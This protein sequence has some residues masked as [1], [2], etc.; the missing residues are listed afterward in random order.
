MEERSDTDASCIYDYHRPRRLCCP[1]VRPLQ[2]DGG[3]SAGHVAGRINDAAARRRSDKFKWTLDAN[4]KGFTAAA[5]TAAVLVSAAQQVNERRKLFARIREP[6]DICRSVGESY[7]CCD[8]TVAMRMGHGTF[9]ALRD[10]AQ[11]FIDFC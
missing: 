6:N 4:S 5:A 3:G 2:P 9:R 11:S 8:I 10:I 7:I 1:D